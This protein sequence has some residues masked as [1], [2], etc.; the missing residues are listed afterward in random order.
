MI[1]F[2]KRK[3]DKQ[4]VQPQK[5]DKTG[6]NKKKKN[7]SSITDTPKLGVDSKTQKLPV[8]QTVQ[9]DKMRIT[10]PK[11]AGQNKIHNQLLDKTH[12]PLTEQESDHHTLYQEHLEKPENLEPKDKNFQQPATSFPQAPPLTD[13]KEIRE[14]SALDQK[15]NNSLEINPDISASTSL[16]LKT[17]KKTKGL[18][19]RLSKG[20][21]RSTEKLMHSFSLKKLDEET[22]DTLEDLLISAD[23]GTKTATQIRDKIATLKFEKNPEQ[24]MIQ[25]A[26]SETIFEQVQH[27]QQA[28]ILPQKQDPEIILFVGVN[29]SG[30]TTTM[31]KLAMHYKQK[32]H[33]IM[34]AAGDTFRSAAIEQL[35]IW[36]ERANIPVISKPIGSDAAALAYDAYL[37]AIKEN[38]DLLMIDTAGRL[39]NKK[40]LMDELAKIIRVLKKINP[41]AP[42]HV[43]L[44]L[45]ASVGQNAHQQTSIFKEIAH[46]TGLIMT[47]LDGTAKGGILVSVCEKQ[48]LP[49][50][51]IGIGEGI[52]DL[53]PFNA[54][55]YANA[56][57]GL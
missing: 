42:H 35:S 51:F 24:R 57:A 45:D 4:E 34:L 56:L 2:L 27:Y 9:K 14:E 15:K 18:F 28:L 31:G 36:G 49:V 33:K 23:L 32:G 46:V 19:S 43:L 25:K 22:L 17:E 48:K 7:A 21:N 8:N 41:K 30:K 13:K 54:K 20:L 6:S 40:T 52:D 47:K 12:T 16:D 3:K 53:I 5:K 50:Y 29:G 39:Q 26:L 55:N 38:A 37:Q 10:P 44:V 1:W 11:N